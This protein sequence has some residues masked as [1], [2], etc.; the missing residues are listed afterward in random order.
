[1]ALKEGQLKKFNSLH[2]QIVAKLQTAQGEMSSG[3]TVI[4]SG[5]ASASGDKQTL[6][7]DEGEAPEAYRKQVADYYRSLTT[8]S[9]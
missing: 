7:G 8:P 5:G 6:G 3:G 2:G 9:P 1:M 4:M